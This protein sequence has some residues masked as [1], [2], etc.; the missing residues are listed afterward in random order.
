[1]IKGHLTEAD[2]FSNAKG[3]MTTKYVIASISA[4]VA[5]IRT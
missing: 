4:N 5:V 1:M 2:E 3:T